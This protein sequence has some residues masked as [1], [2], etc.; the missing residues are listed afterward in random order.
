VQDDIHVS[1]HVLSLGISLLSTEP[2]M[3]I[4]VTKYEMIMP[5]K[6]RISIAGFVKR[7]PFMDFINL[8]KKGQNF[9]AR[10][11]RKH[12][13]SMLAIELNQFNEQSGS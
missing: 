12:D 3:I 4:S 13:R 5:K 6:E 11:S 1:I 9:W 8:F 10:A 2:E 7:R